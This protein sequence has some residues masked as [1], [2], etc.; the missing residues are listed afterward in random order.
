MIREEM[1]AFIGTLILMGIVKLPRFK[2]FCSQDKIIHH[3]SIK[4]NMLQRRLLQIWCYRHLA[5]NST[6]AIPRGADGFDK[7]YHVREYLN[8]IL[9]SIQQEYRLAKNIAIDE[10]MVADKGKLSFKQYI[11]TKSTK[12]DLKLWVLCEATSG[13]CK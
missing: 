6:T 3:E 11:K 12:W 9:R 4:N 7:L 5:D 8:I 13:F 2:M 1:E 10:T